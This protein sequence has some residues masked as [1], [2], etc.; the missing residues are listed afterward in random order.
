MEEWPV[1]H[2]FYNALNPISKSMLDTA[3]GGTFMGKEIEIAT[4]LLID[5]QDNH[6]Q[7]HVERSSSKKVNSVT[8][9]ENEVLTAKVDEL[10]CMIKGNEGNAISNTQIE[11]IFFIAR[12]SN[13][14]AWPNKNF[15]GFQKPYPSNAGVPND[16][17][18]NN[19]KTLFE[20]FGF[21]LHRA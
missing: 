16:Y 5:M 4:K 13:Y 14:P 18:G 10:I 12:N 7:W 3:A 1:L 2:L 15:N 20:F 8:E 6:S 21:L 19:N 11:K 9:A 17:N